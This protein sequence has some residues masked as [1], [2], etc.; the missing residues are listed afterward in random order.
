VKALGISAS[1]EIAVSQHENERLEQALE[2]V[3]PTRREAL[4]KIV[5][6]S[7]FAAPVVASFAVDGLTVS[8]AMA[9]PNSS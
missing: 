6:A 5:R 2:T 9:G 3:D 7:V 4:R 8:P 1:R